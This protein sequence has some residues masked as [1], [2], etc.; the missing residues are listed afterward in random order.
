MPLLHDLG[1]VVLVRL[2]HA[3]VKWLLNIWTQNPRRQEAA[4]P[5][6]ALLVLAFSDFKTRLQEFAPI[7]WQEHY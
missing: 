3:C 5:A 2:V 1:L 6:S 7:Q 4:Q